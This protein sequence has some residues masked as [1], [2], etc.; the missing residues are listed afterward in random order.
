[1]WHRCGAEVEA[2]WRSSHGRP[3]YQ[4]RI[5]E[6]IPGDTGTRHEAEI[7]FVSGNLLS[8]G[9]V[10]GPYADSGRKNSDQLE[11]YWVNFATTGD[12]NRPTVNGLPKWSKFDPTTRPYLEFTE[13][14]GPVVHEGLRREICDLHH[15][16]L[17]QTIPTNKPVE[18]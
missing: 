9:P 2:G 12:P 16:A 18:K 14:D 13:Y 15:E 10:N 1:M 11:T 7:P 17:K 8:S 6:P 5:D 4:Y 3:T